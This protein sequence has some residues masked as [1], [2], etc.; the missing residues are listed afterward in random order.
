MTACKKW[1]ITD[2]TVRL[3]VIFVK[4]AIDSRKVMLLS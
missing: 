2:K 4:N 3:N 1:N